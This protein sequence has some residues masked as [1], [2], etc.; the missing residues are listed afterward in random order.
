MGNTL[1]V[2]VASKRYGDFGFAFLETG[3]NAPRLL[4][5]ADLGVEDP[6]RADTLASAL[7]EF[8]RSESI[9]K[10]LLDGPQG[11]RHPSSPIEHMR[12]CERVINT[13]GKTGTPGNVKP[14]TYLNYVAFSVALFHHLRRDHGWSLLTRSWATK[15]DARWLIEVYPS[16]AW[17]LLGL[18]R[19]PGKARA[20]GKLGL[21]RKALAGVTGYKVPS[22]A[23]H[24]ELQAIVVLPLAEDLEL[25]N[26]EGILLAGID[27]IIEGDTVYEGLI[28][29]PR[30]NPD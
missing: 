22:S 13:P 25:R 15:P 9:D 26:E 30:L 5:A 28:A 17:S 3:S 29:S 10:L 24:D 12:L 21:F 2:D 11:W 20:K 19:L 6:P 18:E 7:A 14:G 8:S 23:T 16:V 1:S 27:P 4:K